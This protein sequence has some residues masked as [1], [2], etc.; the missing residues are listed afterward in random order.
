MKELSTINLTIL[1]YS[2]PGTLVKSVVKVPVSK[3]EG[4]AGFASDCT[5]YNNVGITIM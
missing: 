3:H 2:G 1:G 5:T 4:E